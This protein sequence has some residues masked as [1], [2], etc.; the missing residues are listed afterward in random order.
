[1]YIP[2]LYKSLT[3]PH[4]SIQDCATRICSHH[5]LNIPLPDPT[6]FIQILNNGSTK[7]ITR[8]SMKATLCLRVALRKI[9][10]IIIITDFDWLV[11]VYLPVRVKLQN[12]T[13]FKLRQLQIEVPFFLWPRCK[14]VHNF[15]LY[16]LILWSF[17]E[18]EHLNGNVSILQIY[19][20]DEHLLK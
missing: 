11:K 5:Q 4:Q 18:W 19:V 6:R 3:C 7:Y 13:N 9:I 1:M 15:H 17:C 12:Y 2:V 20:L 8:Q 10:I 16:A 14:P